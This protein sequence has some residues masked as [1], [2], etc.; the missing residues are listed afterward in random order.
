MSVL[1]I[2]QQVSLLLR[3]ANDFPL[4][5]RD[6]LSD[7]IP[8]LAIFSGVYSGAVVFDTIRHHTHVR[9]AHALKILKDF[10]C[11]HRRLQTESSFTSLACRCH[12]AVHA[13]W[14]AAAH[15]QRGACSRPASRSR[16]TTSR[17]SRGPADE[18]LPADV[19]Q[20]AYTRPNDCRP[21]GSRAEVGW[22]RVTRTSSRKNHACRTLRRGSVACQSRLFRHTG[23]AST[24]ANSAGGHAAYPASMRARAVAEARQL[25]TAARQQ[26]QGGRCTW[27][28][29]L[30]RLLATCRGRSERRFASVP[31]LRAA[32]RADP[33]TEPSCCGPTSLA[34]RLALRHACPAMCP[35]LRS[36]RHQPR[37]QRQGRREVVAR[38]E[39]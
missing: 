23:R 21:P 36:V 16:A 18:G 3:F 32:A 35:A 37:R 22:M 9:H 11:S 19:G 24:C 31:R 39:A 38:F 30:A 26:W 2:V 29:T 33:P 13:Q 25:S 20:A 14:R 4:P 12:A 1:T 8:Q 6:F 17:C 28:R 10:C 27:P 15:G 7:A 5:G 34:V